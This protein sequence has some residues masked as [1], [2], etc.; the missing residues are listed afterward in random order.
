MERFGEQSARA[1]RARGLG[2]RAGSVHAG[3][4]RCVS[5]RPGSDRRGG[6]H[7]RELVMAA[8]SVAAVTVGASAASAGNARSM[9]QRSGSRRRDRRG[10]RSGSLRMNA[11]SPGRRRR[12][13]A[14]RRRPVRPDDRRRRPSSPEPGCGG[15]SRQAASGS[16]PGCRGHSHWAGDSPAR[17]MMATALRN[18][19]AASAGRPSADVP[20][21]RTSGSW[22]AGSGRS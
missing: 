11:T 22:P 3:A 7:D 5:A 1:G 2:R 8:D 18:S 6:P 4:R 12:P 14:A 21:R 13:G 19:A 20:G 9:E 15:D 16:T 10:S 17:S